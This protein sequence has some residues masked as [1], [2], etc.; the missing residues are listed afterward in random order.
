MAA[1][2]ATVVSTAMPT[3]VN[4]LG[5]LSLYGWV[6][7]SYLLASTV[8]VPV[9]GK[10]ADL[11]GRKPVLLVGIVLFLA[12]SAASGAART[13]GQLIAFRLLQG[14]GA[15]SVQPVTMTIV[16]DL[17]PAEQRGKVQGLFGAMWGVS[18]IAGPLLGGL[19]VRTLGWRWVFYLN[20]PLGLAALAGLAWAYHESPDERRGQLDVAGAMLLMG[21]STALLLGAS[22][23]GAVWLLPGLVLLAAF[24]VVEQRRREP[25]LP[26]TLVAQRSMA[27][28]TVTTGLFG[29]AMMGS[30]IYMP[31]L[32]QE[33]R[34]GSPT[35]AGATVAPMLIG[36]PLAATLTSRI[37]ARVGYRL[38]LLLGAV[39]VA[40]ASV[41]V[42]AAVRYDQGTMALR[43]LMFVFGLGM[44]MSSM[45]TIVAVQSSVETRQR[46]IA[47]ALN[48]FARSMGG[49][50]GVGALG[51]LLAARLGAAAG[52][53]SAHGGGAA[54]AALGP[55]ERAALGG[56]L[57]GIFWVIAGVGVAN[58]VLAFFYPE[59]PVATVASP[60][61]SDLAAH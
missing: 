36:W 21:S 30:L 43:G 32:I 39:C 12:G 24:I 55:T 44:G 41:G 49:A 27:I 2:E 56:A 45:S 50:L 57:G 52:H 29:V 20:V 46:G 23:Q 47:T 1:L 60:A 3:V 42:A 18:G 9:F 54:Q 48:M 5:G 58:L 61:P 25:L 4:D 14:V 37:L 11:R 15:G 8:S 40:V 28:A 16:G 10:L 31:L 35:E 26:L 19:I 6:G 7:A 51:G 13:I 59:R 22:G 38:P 33:V 17:Y 53:V 34:G